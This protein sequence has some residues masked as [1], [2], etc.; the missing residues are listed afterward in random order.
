MRDPGV[1]CSRTQFGQTT[2]LKRFVRTSGIQAIGKGSMTG[3]TAEQLLRDTRTTSGGAVSL[4]CSTSP[5]QIPYTPR[6][7]RATRSVFEKRQVPDGR[8]RN[9]MAQ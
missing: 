3:L 7:Q 1:E 8:Y 6:R 4:T 9:L 5:S 2:P